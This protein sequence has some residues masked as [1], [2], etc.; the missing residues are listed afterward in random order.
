MG[1]GVAAGRASGCSGFLSS[2]AFSRAA[3]VGVGLDFFGG[4]ALG[5]GVGVAVAVPPTVAPLGAWAPVTGFLFSVPGFEA[6]AAVDA[7]P[8]PAAGLPVAAGD[9]GGAATAEDGLTAA[10]GGTTC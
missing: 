7:A 6:A 3:G 4:V 8:G 5:F 10:L 1:V 9:L 2:G